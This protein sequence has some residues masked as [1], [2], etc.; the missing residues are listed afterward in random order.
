M[1][2]INEILAE[3]VTGKCYFSIYIDRIIYNNDLVIISTYMRLTTGHRRTHKRER[4]DRSSHEDT[5]WIGNFILLRSGYRFIRYVYL[6][7]KL[8]KLRGASPKPQPY[9]WKG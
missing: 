6:N 9:T 4:L 8:H 2:A 5:G 7:H 3:S 1:A